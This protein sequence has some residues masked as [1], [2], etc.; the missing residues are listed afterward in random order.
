MSDKEQTN[1]QMREMLNTISGILSDDPAQRHAAKLNMIRKVCEDAGAAVVQ[2]TAIV[3]RV[4]HHV[5]RL[6]E[7]ASEEHGHWLTDQVEAMADEEKEG[8][9]PVT[10]QLRDFVL[11]LRDRIEPIAQE[12]YDNDPV[13]RAYEAQDAAR[14][15][16]NDGD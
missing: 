6:T 10:E 15:A 5:G 8:S 11:E 16:E 13:R 7:R 2:F 1:A 3:Y 14:D 4:P 12:L 9:G